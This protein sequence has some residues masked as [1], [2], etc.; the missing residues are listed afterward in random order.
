MRKILIKQFKFNSITQN[1]QNFLTPITKRNQNLILTGHP[2]EHW[3]VKVALT[4]KNHF[5]LSNQG[6]PLNQTRTIT[7]HG[8]MS[9]ATEP[10]D[11]SD[12][13]EPSDRSPDVDLFENIPDLEHKTSESEADSGKTY[14]QAESELEASLD[15]LS[16]VSTD[17]SISNS[18]ESENEAELTLISHQPKT[19]PLPTD[20]KDLYT[21]ESTEVFR[22]PILR[23]LANLK[24][25]ERTQDSDSSLISADSSFQSAESSLSSS[26]S[27][28]PV[29]TWKLKPNIVK[30]QFFQANSENQ[31]KIQQE[32]TN[33]L[34][35]KHDQMLALQASAIHYNNLSQ[36]DKDRIKAE[37]QQKIQQN[38]ETYKSFSSITKGFAAISTEYTHAPK[39]EPKAI[40]NQKE[41][42]DLK[43]KENSKKECPS[44][45]THPDFVPK[46][47]LT[48]A[49]TNITVLS[50]FPKTL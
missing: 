10:S 29:S 43:A 12:P 1:E 3:D 30:N 19:H 31:R 5:G 7:D 48:C 22:T 26:P 50:L 35:D 21:P 18:E 28:M 33:A 36:E 47:L 4:H 13:S 32:K 27:T 49:A 20:F 42:A 24:F 38:K 23:S 14:D 39:V 16:S 9:Q 44:M 17:D 41:Q 11:P 37:K 6:P 46:P 40:R 25:Q 45:W 2:D 34:Q 8:Y 15:Q